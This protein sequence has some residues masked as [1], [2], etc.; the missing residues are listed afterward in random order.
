MGMAWAAYLVSLLLL[1][2]VG[3]AEQAKN[4]TKGLF[5]TEIL[6][7][8]GPPILLIR[9][10]R[11]D[12]RKTLQL[13]VLKV[14]PGIMTILAA[15]STWVIVVEVSAIQNDIFPYPQSFLD[16][17][18]EIFKVFHARGMGYSLLMMA[19][20][21]AVCEETL[22]RGFILTGFRKQ[23][24]ATRAVILTAVIFGLFHLSPYRYLP[25]GLLGLLIGAV[26]IWTGSLYAGMV[27]H[28]IVNGASALVFQLTYQSTN[29]TMVSLREGTYLPIWLVII[30]VVVAVFSI[31]S[32]FLGYRRSLKTVEVEG[33]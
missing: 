4:L 10:F 17:F 27:A 14:M 12:V 3:Q 29:P 25:T 24:G 5:L 16:A 22:F 28:F 11:Y 7:V 31:R 6:L 26:V 15:I 21:P 19:V 13:N 1:F 23:W 30:A 2:Y 20:L 9:Y 32:L 18:E 33:E 8:A